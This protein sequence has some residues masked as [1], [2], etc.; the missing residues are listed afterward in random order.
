MAGALVGCSSSGSSA[1][2]S[3]DASTAVAASSASSE[4]TALQDFAALPT[5]EQQ[6]RLQAVTERLDR[7]LIAMSGLEEELGGA[8]K[9]D[10]AYVAL[11]T[12]AR[13]LAQSA[14]DQPDF[15]RFGGYVAAADA[16]TQGGLMFGNFMAGVLLQD[17]AVDV[18][19]DVAPGTKANA[20]SEPLQAPPKGGKGE[21]IFEG[22]LTKSSVG[23]EGEFTTDGITGKL[24]TVIT[25]APCPDPKGEFTSTTTMTASIVSGRGT[26]SNLMIEM[27]IKGQVDDDAQLVSYDIDTR[28][29]SAQFANGKG[30]YADQS[31][32]WTTTGDIAGNYR[33]KVNRTGGAVT[34]EFVTD[35]GKWSL[36]TAVMMK[37]KAVEAAKR[38]WQ[39]G[40]CVTLEPTTEP[41]KRKGLKPSDAVSI[42]A[43]PRSKVDGG[44]VGGT[45]TAT[46]NGDSSV[47][48]A[49]S[50][51]KADA[52]FAY[53]APTDK[54][55]SATVSLEARSKRGV[56]KAEVAFDTK[57]ASYTASGKQGSLTFSGTV[58]DLSQPF[59]I[60]AAGGAQGTFS[61]VPADETGRS[62]AMSYVG[63][64]GGL[65][66]TDSGT[67]T[68]TG[69]D[70]GVLTLTQTHGA[71]KAGSITCA[72]GAAKITLTPAG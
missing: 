1:G 57:K 65:K 67:Y 48:P 40:R 53:V 31:V 45:V 2:D 24:K 19:K 8:A 51:V 56:A 63:N 20:G 9:A 26:G 18:A 69:D 38:G 12:M 52:K 32:G 64:V 41:S 3:A 59:T 55:K 15:G 25:V 46:L 70:G 36:F 49:G 27:K 11:S 30:V 28:T 62:G 6:L 39:S 34:E 21:I 13:E 33:A 71:C 37:D 29:E 50:K 58:S 44:P 47:D 10:A 54:D 61:Y 22:D 17:A 16:P 72:G 35:Q 14:I 43:A 5:A 42:T 4:L 66:M 60:A 68:I 23:L 7:Q